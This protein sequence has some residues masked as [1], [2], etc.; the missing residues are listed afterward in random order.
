V[1]GSWWLLLRVYRRLNGAKFKVIS[2]IEVEHL[3]VK[4]STDEWAELMPDDARS[5]H[6]ARLG[7]AFREL[8][9]VERIVPMV[10]GLLY[11]VLLIGRL[12]A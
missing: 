8:G 12:T 3:P 2:Q 5:G 9:G 4:P 1:A 7:N 10:F 11:V 6:R